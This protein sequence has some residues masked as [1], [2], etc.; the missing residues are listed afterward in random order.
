MLLSSALFRSRRLAT[1]ALQHSNQAL[2]KQIAQLTET[3]KLLVNTLA[4]ERHSYSELRD[5]ERQARLGF[6]AARVGTWTWK[7]ESS[8][9]I[10]D[11]QLRELYGIVAP[12]GAITTVDQIVAAIYADDRA[13]LLAAIRTVLEN[14]IE[15]NI[16]F[17]VV[18]PEGSLHWVGA[19]GAVLVGP[20]GA[21]AGMTGVTFDIHARKTAE[22]AL[23]ESENRFRTLADS[24]PQLAWIADASGVHHWFNR[25]WYEYTGT[26]PI[27]MQTAGWESFLHPDDRAQLADR[28]RLSTDTGAPLS[29]ECRLRGDNGQYRCFLRLATPIHDPSGRV[30]SWFGT[31]TDITEMRETR[32]ALRESEHQFRGIADS[33]PQLVWVTRPDG[34]LEWWNRQWSAFTGASLD[35]MGPEGWFT[36]FHVD[37]LPA[38]W[39]KWRDSLRTGKP[40]QVTNRIRGADG[41]YRWFLVRAIPVLGVGGAIVKWFGTCTDIDDHKNAESQIQSLNENLEVRVSE[42]TA[43]LA[44]ANDVLDQTRSHLQAILDAAIR[45]SIIVTDTEGVITAFNRGA[46]R[47]L[48]YDAA[49]MIGQ[50]SPLQFHTDTELLKQSRLLSNQLQR[51]V[52]G[53]D[54][55]REVVTL[56]ALDEEEWTYV[57]KDR[58][59]LPVLLA[60]TAVRNCYNVV[61]GYLHIASDITARKVLEHGL[62][63]TN[64]QLLK[65]TAR[66]EEAN[67]AKSAFLAAMS[68]EIRTPMNAIL[69]MSD[70]L[71]ESQ[72]EPEQR[73]YVEVFRRAGNVLLD[74]INSVLDLSKIE[75]GHLELESSL[76]DLE[77]VVTRAVE[78]IQPKARA[79]GIQLLF[80]IAPEVPAELIGDAFRLQQILVNL[81]GNAV[82]FTPAGEVV[83]RVQCDRSGTPGALEFSVSDTGVG[84]TPE[85]IQR[86]FNDF[87]QA[88]A[89]TTRKYGGT[90]LGLGIAQRLIGYMGG[91]L[92]VTSQQNVGSI[93]R[94][95][96]VLKPGSD[97]RGFPRN[98]FMDLHGLRI[99]VIDNNETNRQILRETLTSWGLAS[100]ERDSAESGSQELARA[101]R[102]EEPYSIVL[103]D[104][105]M[106]YL[107]GFA[108]V[109]L[110]RSTQP[111]IPIVMLT[112]DSRPG[113]NARR[114]AYRLSGY[115]V[116]PVK[117]ADLL[118]LIC[119]A[120]G[121]AG[122]SLL[123]ASG[124]SAE[125]GTGAAP[126]TTPLHILIAEDSPDNRLLLSAY[127]RNSPFELT[128]AE[129]GLEALE[130]FRVHVFDLVLMDMQMPVMDGITATRA[131]RAFESEN[132]RPPVPIIALTA[133]VLTQDAATSYQAGCN[134]HLSKPIS[135]QKLLLAI[136]RHAPARHVGHDADFVWISA[137]EGLE[138]IAP[139]YLTSRIDEL[140]QL[141]QLAA[142]SDFE[143]LRNRGHDLKGSGGSFGFDE[144]TRIGAEIEQFAKQR[145]A[146]EISHELQQ[147]GLYLNR[148]RISPPSANPVAG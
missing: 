46:E 117:R 69:G 66:A 14:G 10:C 8:E 41:A 15:F 33:M 113:D 59:T 99:L 144:I 118:Q 44:A 104:G 133:N 38:T 45:V 119:N 81:I 95:N 1:D 131:L 11:G 22:L 85:H 65:Q 51:P 82:K 54:V 5:R 101:Q 9:L 121:T 29:M 31:D 72:L 77:D 63:E 137:P 18:H 21:P 13:S 19:S 88:D 142:A 136:Q 103:L 53:F 83:L 49:E 55:F 35:D 52:Q 17:R 62:R 70:L 3:E 34:C 48:Q 132:G 6:K 74:L 57:R 140:P 16:E 73:Q 78:L 143:A 86:I 102:N 116:K 47:M 122:K 92:S 4:A 107:D 139:G 42:R 50:A 120:L 100:V 67:L 89:S 115:A 126:A 56:G 79:Q 60:T 127:L 94:F 146:A 138:E 75:A 28:W 135:K 90:G 23:T 141:L 148:V 97:R 12:A 98:E 111:N 130:R 112:S 37:D 2:T 125:S 24:I 105:Q 71:W 68:H 108:A 129:N 114:T 20:D 134:L 124:P 25:R 80:R 76:F 110:L 145:K 87:H 93:F 147:L 30:T 64:A 27:Q 128:F 61:T 58:S 7:L 106:P 43:Q 32:D 91:Q 84:I 36:L 26:A 109:P 96:V 40:L 39:A 123:L